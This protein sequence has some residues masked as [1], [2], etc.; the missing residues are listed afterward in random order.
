MTHNVRRIVTAHDKDGISVVASNGPAPV[1]VTPPQSPGLAFI[2]IWN[3]SSSP[4][5]IV[6]AE[7]DPTVGR[8]LI[9]APPKGGTIIRVVDIPPENPAEMDAATAQ[10]VLARVG[11]DHAA[12]KKKPHP[13]M[14][15]TESVDYGIVLSGE[16]DLVLDRERVSLKQGDVVVQRGTDHAWS[17]RSG[18][19][20]R[21]AFV[22]VSGRFSDDLAAKIK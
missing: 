18:R 12:D 21:M 13:F 16:I 20:C 1:V 10:A 15:R 3:T 17:N 5:P 19:P 7:P 14:H 8:P 6:A 11:L 4:A 9:T 22:L 2:E